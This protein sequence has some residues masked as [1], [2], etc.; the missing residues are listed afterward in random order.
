M[1]DLKP[2]EPSRLRRALQLHLGPF[3]QFK[4]IAAV[5]RADCIGLGNVLEP[6]SPVLSN[7]FVEAA[8]YIFALVPDDDQGFVDEMIEQSKGVTLDP[9][10]IASTA[11]IVHPPANTDSRRSSAFSGSVCGVKLQSIDARRV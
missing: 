11:S 6:L 3:G 9:L 2:V 8:A 5:F 7:S 4:E 1:V 10:Q